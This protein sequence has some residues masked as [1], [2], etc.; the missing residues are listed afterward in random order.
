MWSLSERSTVELEAFA[1]ATVKDTSH[2]PRYERKPLY[3]KGFRLF[4][5]PY[6]GSRRG[7][8]A[9]PSREAS[10]WARH[11]LPPL[12]P[13]HRLQWLAAAQILGS[14]KPDLAIT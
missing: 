14:R 5:M 10:D 12:R 2:Y 13:P 7:P 1:R 4:R 8:I 11:E 3:H 9:R 6:I